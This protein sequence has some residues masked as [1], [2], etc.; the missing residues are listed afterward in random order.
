MQKTIIAT[1]LLIFLGNQ[2]MA[3]ELPLWEVAVGAGSISQAYNTGT[4]QT[5]S[6]IFPVIVP[7]YRGDFLKS[8][9][10]G[11]RAEFF[12]KPNVKL[13]LS[14]DF[15]LGIASKHVDLR[16]GMP[17]VPNQLQIGPSL[18]VT[19]AKSERRKWLLNLPARAVFAIDSDNTDIAGYNFSPNIS[20]TRYFSTGSIPWR[21]TFSTQLQFGTADYH[22]F[23]Y[24]VEPEYATDKRPSYNVNTGYS[25]ARA[26]ASFV[27]KTSRNLFAAFARYDN[28][29]GAVFDD[30]PL[31]E[32]N[33][34]ISVGL[35]YAYYL[36]QSKKQVNVEP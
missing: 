29:S 17:D 7:V 10:R 13:E 32:T 33:E 25:G 14:M 2:S 27:S 3:E 4:K 5:R 12:K 23:Y 11:F 35:L 15:N 21:A 31:V 19:L 36:F 28:I 26:T 30:S 9:D 16:R 34:N 24:E 6:Y 18:E 22:R 8:D 20:Y 1:L